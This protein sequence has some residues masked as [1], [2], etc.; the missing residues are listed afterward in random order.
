MAIIDVKNINKSYG[1]R[2]K[3]VKVLHDIDIQVEKGEIFGLLGKNGAGK[4]TLIKVLSGLLVPDQAE[5]KVL[6][7]DVLRESGKI[8]ANVS[9]VA[10]TVDVGVDPVLTVKQNLLFWATVYG[11]KKEETEKVVIDVMK[12][13]DLLR[14]ENAWAME[15]SA[16]TRQRLAIARALLVKHDLVFLDEPTVKLDMEA[17][18]M[19]RD[20]IV[21]LRNKFGITFFMTTHLIEEAEEICDRVMILDNGKVKAIG[22]IDDLRKEFSQQET[23]EI[24]G[25]F[26]EDCI[27]KLKKLW[28]LE[29]KK[30]DKYVSLIFKVNS[31][32]KSLSKIIEHIEKCG[33]ITNLEVKRLSLDEIFEK[34]ISL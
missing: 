15:I 6:G 26:N 30:S 4:T 10:P 11:I 9:L 12:T 34:V 3:R 14:Y 33:E 16:G 32:E 17:A 5:G 27:E 23:V 25:I 22:N 8:R 19:I 31:V 24:K 21:D 1:K 13:L 7:Y 2:N 29:L 20:V 28:D 18:K